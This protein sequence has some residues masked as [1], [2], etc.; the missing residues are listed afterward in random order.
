MFKN[1]LLNFKIETKLRTTYL[2]YLE[3]VFKKIIF[4]CYE[5]KNIIIKKKSRKEKRNFPR[6]LHKY[7]YLKS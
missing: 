4:L 1:I 3:V 6:K 7:I 5:L 2:I